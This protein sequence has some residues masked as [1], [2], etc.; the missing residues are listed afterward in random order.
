MI[1]LKFEHDQKSDWLLIKPIEDK[2]RPIELIGNK[3]WQSDGLQEDIEWTKQCK[4]GI[5]N[6]ED[7]NDG[8][9]IGI[10]GSSGIITVFNDLGGFVIDQYDDK[11]YLRLTFDEV[12]SILHQM[13]DFLKSIDK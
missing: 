8:F 12:L 7:G 2:Y 4:A 5:F 1:K 10:E 9:D 6:D 3:H 13:Y 11:E